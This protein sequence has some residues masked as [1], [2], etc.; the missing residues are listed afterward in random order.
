MPLRGVAPARAREVE[1]TAA[2]S[3]IPAP[4]REVMAVTR[5][6]VPLRRPDATGTPTPAATPA[7][8]TT[9]T[10]IRP[11]AT[12]PTTMVEAMVGEGSM[13]LRSADRMATSTQ[14]VYIVVAFGESC[15]LTRM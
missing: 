12:A 2:V 11:E 3:R 14:R 1:I 15:G 13:R 10:A 9:I 8:A 6:L 4:P 5:T 7:P